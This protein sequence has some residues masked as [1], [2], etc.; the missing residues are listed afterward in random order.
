[1]VKQESS[2][3]NELLDAEVLLYLEQTLNGVDVTLEA[4]DYWKTY[5]DKFPK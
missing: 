2:S 5:H 3:G 1:M 4:L